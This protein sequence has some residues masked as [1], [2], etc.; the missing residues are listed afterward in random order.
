MRR[1]IVREYAEAVRGRYS[2]VSRSEKG[3]I[4]DEFTAVTGNH[5]KSAIR[6]LSGQTSGSTFLY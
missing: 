6:Q 2:G 1:S 4:L 3:K 5:R